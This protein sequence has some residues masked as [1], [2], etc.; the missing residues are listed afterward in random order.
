MSKMKQHG[1]S[2]RAFMGRAL[3]AG[4][5]VVG[6]ATILGGTEARAQK[7]PK[8]SVAYQEEPKGDQNCANCQFWVEPEAGAEMGGCQIVQGKISPDAWC[9]LWAKA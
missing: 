2:R 9:N 8:Q 3:G 1:C 6:A 5:A 7:A 4:A